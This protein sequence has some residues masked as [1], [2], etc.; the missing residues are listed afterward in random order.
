MSKIYT[1]ISVGWLNILDQETWFN[2]RI[3]NSIPSTKC[4]FIHR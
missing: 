4:C 3:C 1:L 2:I